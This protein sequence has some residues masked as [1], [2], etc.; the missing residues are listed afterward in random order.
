MLNEQIRQGS[1]FLLYVDAD[2]LPS[3]AIKAATA[4][5]NVKDGMTWKE[6]ATLLGVATSSTDTYRNKVRHKLG[7]SSKKV[8]LQSALHSLARSPSVRKRS[9]RTQRGTEKRYAG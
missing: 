3:G 6:I 8:N 7:L 1:H 4:Q 5:N 2:A 9:R